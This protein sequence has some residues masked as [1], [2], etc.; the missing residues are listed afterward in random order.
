[1][2]VHTISLTGALVLILLAILFW[3]L[4][5]P[6]GLLVLIFAAVLLWYAFGPGRTTNLSL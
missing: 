4:I 5:G 1:M 6:I 2:A 3:F